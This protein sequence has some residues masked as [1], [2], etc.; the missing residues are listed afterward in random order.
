MAE[1]SWG[2]WDAMTPREVAG[3]LA[4]LDAPWW[5]A[6]GYAI[7]AFA[8]KVFRDHGDVDVGLLRRDQLATQRHLADW[9]RTPLTRPGNC[10]H[11]RSARASNP[12]CTIS[13]RAAGQSNRGGSS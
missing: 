5:I 10:G 4:G 7:E 1:T 2:A 12:G 6:G 9:D 8:G 13:G 11:G 3:L